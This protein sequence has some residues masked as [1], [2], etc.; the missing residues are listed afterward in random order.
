[1]VRLMANG[2]SGLESYEGVYEIRQ[3]GVVQLVACKGVK[4]TI[5]ISSRQ[6]VYDCDRGKAPVE[7]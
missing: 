1:M 7:S 2:G 5:H 3:Y 4:M 6:H